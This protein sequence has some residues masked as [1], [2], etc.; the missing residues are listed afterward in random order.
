MPP[1]T[2]THTHQCLP[3][4]PPSTSLHHPAIKSWGWGLPHSHA[5]HPRSLLPGSSP[6]PPS[7]TP[8]CAARWGFPLLFPPR[9]ISSRRY[10]ERQLQIMSQCCLSAPGAAPAWE[11]GVVTWVAISRQVPYSPDNLQ[12]SPEADP[13]QAGR[14]PWEYRS[15]VGVGMPTGLQP[16]PE[17]WAGSQPSPSVS[18]LSRERKR[19]R[20]RSEVRTLHAG[21]KKWRQKPLGVWSPS[22]S[23]L[24]LPGLSLLVNQMGML[25]LPALRGALRF[26]QQ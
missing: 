20:Q 14:A 9:L 22:H 4:L 18:A 10:P 11:N 17:H 24:Y 15:T 13:G 7:L 2:H 3:A 12:L 23:C 16:G 1:S 21:W 26:T 25:A 19:H 5:P 6:A 8:P